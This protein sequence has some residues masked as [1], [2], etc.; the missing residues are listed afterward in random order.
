M[1]TSFVAFTSRKITSIWLGDDLRERPLGIHDAAYMT[2]VPM[3]AR[4]MV[5]ASFGQELGELPA[6]TPDTAKKN[7]RGDKK[8]PQ[9]PMPLLYRKKFVEETDDTS[10]DDE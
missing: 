7:D 1:D 8:G 6:S 10:L 2:V 4:Y 3:W 9:H 5:R